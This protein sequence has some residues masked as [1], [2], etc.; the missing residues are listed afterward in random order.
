MHNK[1]RKFRGPSKM[2]ILQ[3]DDWSSNSQASIAH[4]IPFGVS[5]SDK[6]C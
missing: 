4:A 5:I 1:G 2:K 3:K 6:K